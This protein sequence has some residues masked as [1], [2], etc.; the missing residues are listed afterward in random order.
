[1]SAPVGP[2]ST[3]NR[4][5][6]DSN[7]KS[8]ENRE[9]FNTPLYGWANQPN[10]CIPCTCSRTVDQQAA[11]GLVQV[12]CQDKHEHPTVEWGCTICTFQSHSFNY[13]QKHMRRKHK[14]RQRGYTPRGTLSEKD[15]AV[16]QRELTTIRKEAQRWRE[17]N[18]RER[19]N[20]I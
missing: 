12:F 9:T 15:R 7:P 19:M 5:P 20:H 13:A 18:G 16:H 14:V 2:Q 8:S 6:K 3:P 1:V 11:A 10:V 17:E 4:S